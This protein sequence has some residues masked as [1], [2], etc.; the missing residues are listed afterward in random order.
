[1][2]DFAN[3]YTQIDDLDSTA[4]L[5]ATSPAGQNIVLATTNTG[6]FIEGGN[7]VE[8]KTTATGVNTIEIDN[9]SGGANK[10]FKITEDDFLIW[11]Y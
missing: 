3:D 4:N 11:I 5:T 1:M 8:W 2:A 6:N 9:S 10:P 7:A